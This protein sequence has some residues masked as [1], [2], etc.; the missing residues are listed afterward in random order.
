[1][2]HHTHFAPGLNSKGAL[3]AGERSCDRFERF[4]PLDIQVKRFAA[5]A[6]SAARNGVDRLNQKSLN[7]LWFFVVVVSSDRMHNCG[8]SSEP[9]RDISTDECVRPLDFVVHCFPNIVQQRRSFCNAD[10]SPKLGSH[11]CGE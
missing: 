4:E 5:C 9:T 3:D 6:G 7:R 1:M 11:M 8:R 10:I 2:Y